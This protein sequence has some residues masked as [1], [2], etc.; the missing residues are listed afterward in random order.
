MNAMR[1]YIL[2]GRVD[3][4]LLTPIL[5]NPLRLS[6]ILVLRRMRFLLRRMCPRLLLSSLLGPRSRVLQLR[7]P[8]LEASHLDRMDLGTC[9]RV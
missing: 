8:L 5:V 9:Q 6:A 2:V 3:V 1:T 7:R 4:L